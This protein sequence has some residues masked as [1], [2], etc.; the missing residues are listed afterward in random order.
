MGKPYEES[1]M[2]GYDSPER[3]N[4]CLNCG[5]PRCDL[6]HAARGRHAKG[7]V[8]IGADGEEV[9]FSGTKDAAERLGVSRNS[10]SSAIRNGGTCAGYLWTYEK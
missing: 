4:R 1:M 9:H 10:I 8:G 5:K 2:N 7:V 6:C 3:I